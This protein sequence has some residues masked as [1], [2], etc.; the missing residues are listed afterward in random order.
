MCVACDFY[1]V[2]NTKNLLSKHIANFTSL[3]PTFEYAGPSSYPDLV[4]DREMLEKVQR[5]ATRLSFGCVRPTH[6]ERLDMANLTAFE[7]DLI[8][9][10][11]IL[12][13]NFGDLKRLPPSVW[14]NISVGTL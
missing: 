3:R 1:I 5:R 9:S 8:L 12:K 2:P 14:T 13:F 7:G 10:F 11:R 6:E 4:R